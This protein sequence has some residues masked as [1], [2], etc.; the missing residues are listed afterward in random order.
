MSDFKWLSDW[1]DR[2]IDGWMNELSGVGPIREDRWGVKPWISQ[3]IRKDPSGDA[4]ASKNSHRCVCCMNQILYNINM[5]F[6]NSCWHCWDHA[7]KNMKRKY[8]NLKLPK[9]FCEALFFRFNIHLP[10]N[11][12]ESNKVDVVFFFF[13]KHWKLKLK[14]MQERF[15]VYGVSSHW[16]LS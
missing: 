16:G 8:E 4:G 7:P 1:L 3:S 11:T 5:S 9:Y 14:P 10:E 13:Q 2:W 6:W 15:Q 12:I